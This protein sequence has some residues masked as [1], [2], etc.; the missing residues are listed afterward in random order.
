MV[1]EVVAFPGPV[2]AHIDDVAS[3]RLPQNFDNVPTDRVVVAIKVGR[4]GKQEF[5]R[6]HPGG[7]YRGDFGLLLFEED[8]EFY[9]V[10][11]ALHVEFGPVLRRTTLVATINR[12]GAIRLWP[13][14]LPDLATGRDNA[15]FMSAR[16]VAEVARTSWV[17]LINANDHYDAIKAAGQYGEPE[18]PNLTFDEMVQ[19]AFRDRIIDSMTHPVAR[20]LNGEV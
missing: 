4:P 6:V 11:P 20:K 9:V 19:V 5:F 3:L 15:W 13:I 17:R 8:R 18:W 2:T 16:T 1:D 10:A 12:Y 14:G 7:A